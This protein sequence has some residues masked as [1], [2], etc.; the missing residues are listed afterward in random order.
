MLLV[1]PP[2]FIIIIGILTAV[3]IGVKTKG[4]LCTLVIMMTEVDA[5]LISI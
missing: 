3:D 2:A 4:T 1:V 5:S